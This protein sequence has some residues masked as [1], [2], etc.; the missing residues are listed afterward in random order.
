[1]KRHSALMPLSQDHHAESYKLGGSV[2]PRARVLPRGTG[3]GRTAVR[4]G[5][6]TETVSRF[7]VEGQLFALLERHA[8]S[9]LSSS[10]CSS[11]TK[12][13]R[14]LASALREEAA[15]GDVTGETM[16]Q[17]ADLLDANVRREERKLFPL[18]EMTPRRRTARPRP[19]VIGYCGVRTGMTRPTPRVSNDAAI[20]S[21]LKKNANCANPICYGLDRVDSR[22]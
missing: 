15:L 9:V 20:R 12:N 16:V 14:A 18:I 19:A 10:G 2:L 4:R 21:G 17:L 7:R 13:I 5:F 6:F 3:C 8:G 22:P 11:S 1:M